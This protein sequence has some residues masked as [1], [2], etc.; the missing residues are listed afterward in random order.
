VSL[1]AERGRLSTAGA[2]ALVVGSMLGTG[3]FTTTGFV[4]SELGSP[5]VVLLCWVVGGLLALS[6]AAVYAELGAMLPRVGGEYVYLSRA[7]HPSRGR[8]RCRQR[9]LPRALSPG[10]TG[11]GGWNRGKCPVSPPGNPGHQ[12]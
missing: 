5:A 12:R 1:G 8:G 3:V 7:F 9:P 2:V 4:L 11:P 6:G 10:G